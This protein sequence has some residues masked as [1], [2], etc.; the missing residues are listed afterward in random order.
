MALY[1]MPSGELRTELLLKRLGKCAKLVVRVRVVKTA[2]AKFL[3][4]SA[5]TSD[6]QKWMTG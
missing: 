1:A 3:I 2:V 4:W 6:R 5:F